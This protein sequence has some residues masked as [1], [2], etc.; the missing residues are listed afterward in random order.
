MHL[1][2]RAAQH[3]NILRRKLNVM[4]IDGPGPFVDHGRYLREFGTDFSFR[5][6]LASVSLA[7]IAQTDHSILAYGSFVALVLSNTI[8]NGSVDE[9][10]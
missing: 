7:N 4:L 8:S 9:A 3:F 6:P 10:V 2:G 1:C 5:K